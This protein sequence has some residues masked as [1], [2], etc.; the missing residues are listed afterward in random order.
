[1]QTKMPT[2]P[3]LAGGL[4][5]VYMR[6]NVRLYQYDIGGVCIRLGQMD[7]RLDVHLVSLAKVK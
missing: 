4:K 2:E 6:L 7:V 3:L 5:F 1:M